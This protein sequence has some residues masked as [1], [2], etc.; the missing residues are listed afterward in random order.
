MPNV[1]S[2]SNSN[3]IWD[4][5]L[6]TT[7]KKKPTPI[8]FNEDPVAIACA[9]WRLW[10]QGGS[11]WL[12]LDSARAQEQDHER[13]GLLRSYYAGKM[14]FDAIKG[15]GLKTTFRQKLYAIVSNCHEYTNEDVL[16]GDFKLVFRQPIR[17]L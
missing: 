7:P 17:R 10:K 14:T 2:V 1:I 11:R 13:A 4:D 15:Q 16:D 5:W 3:G 6:D 9:S 8:T 12:D